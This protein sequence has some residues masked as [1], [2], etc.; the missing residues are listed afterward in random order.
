MSVELF[1]FSEQSELDVDKLTHKLGET[2]GSAN[3]LA[4]SLLLPLTGESSYMW[5][6]EE[7]NPKHVKL[8]AMLKQRFP[9]K[10]NFVIC[11]TSN[12]TREKW[13]ANKSQPQ[14]IFGPFFDD[15]VSV[16]RGFKDD[17]VSDCHIWELMCEG[18]VND[19]VPE[20]PEKS[21]VPTLLMLGLFAVL[22][23]ICGYYSWTTLTSLRVTEARCEELQK[24]LQAKK[25]EIEKLQKDFQ[26]KQ[27]EG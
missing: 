11:P 18:Q 8:C 6:N 20:K 26:T 5:L 12:E 7:H 4:V 16:F 15:N 27:A 21:K 10:L 22:L 25:V 24:D 17:V 3:V 9:K 13:E 14:S 1:R 23:A 19:V 2:S